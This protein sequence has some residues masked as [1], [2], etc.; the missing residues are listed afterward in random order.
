MALALPLVAGAVGVGIA[1]LT[2]ALN[3]HKIGNQDTV[4]RLAP[5]H[6]LQAVANSTPNEHHTAKTKLPVS[7]ESTEQ[8]T[9]PNGV[10]ST[11]RPLPG[12]LDRATE[13]ARPNAIDR[14][15]SGNVNP[16]GRMPRLST[17][18]ARYGSA[19]MDPR[20]RVQYQRFGT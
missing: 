15:P 18:R 16:S 1:G 14:Q 2:Q 10:R 3:F 20:L 11:R 5:A 12:A 7:H 6:Q 4:T 9:T 8:T 17:L 19:I 13:V